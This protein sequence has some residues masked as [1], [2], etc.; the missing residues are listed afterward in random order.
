[1][2]ITDARYLVD[3]NG[4]NY[5]VFCMIDG[6]VNSVPMKEGNR[7]YDEIMRQLNA[8]ELTIADAD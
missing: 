8:G 2:N 7:H 6:V 5:V 1:M 4:N 3:E